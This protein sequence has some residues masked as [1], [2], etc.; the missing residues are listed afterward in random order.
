MAPASNC[1]RA[2][3]RTWSPRSAGSR[4]GPSASSPT[5]RSGSVAAIR[6]LHRRT[7][8]EVP[9]DKLHAVET[10]LAAEHE[11]ETGGLQRARDIGVIDEVIEPSRTREAIA[12]AIAEAPQRRGR[13]GNIPL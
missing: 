3:R 8:A 1:T 7:L 9:P 6:I 11:R 13:H 12:R 4:A 2:G 10:D 5:T